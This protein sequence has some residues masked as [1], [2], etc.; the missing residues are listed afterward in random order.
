[1]HSELEEVLEEFAG[2]GIKFKPDS[3]RKTCTLLSYTNTVD[4]IQI[5]VIARA[6][7]KLGMRDISWSIAHE[8]CHNLIAQK[9]VSKKY[10]KVFGSEDEWES[11]QKMFRWVRGNSSKYVTRYAATHP[12]EDFC[13]CLVA[14]IL[15]P[16]TSSYPVVNRKLKAAAQW[17]RLIG[18]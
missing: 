8:I 15:G 16:S 11:G 14:Q 7:H 18:K 13:E 12:E 10:R 2:W 3:Y 5:G 6:A 4:D 1:M 17:L 9:G